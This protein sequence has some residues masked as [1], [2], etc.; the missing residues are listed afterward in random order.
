MYESHRQEL[1]SDRKLKQAW[2][3]FVFGK[4]LECDDF[5]VGLVICL[6]RLFGQQTVSIRKQLTIRC[7]RATKR[8]LRDLNVDAGLYFTRRYR[9]L[10]KLFGSNVNWDVGSFSTSK[11]LSRNGSLPRRA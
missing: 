7:D 3:R 9:G 6:E 5:Q 8:E 1:K 2:D 11:S 10:R 4:P